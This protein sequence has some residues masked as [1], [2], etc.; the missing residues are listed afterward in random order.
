MKNFIVQS[1]KIY[2][3]GGIKMVELEKKDFVKGNYEGTTIKIKSLDIKPEST[4]HISYTIGANLDLDEARKIHELLVKEF[5][6]N[7]VIATVEEV[8]IGIE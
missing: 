5:P 6:N 8:E 3:G 4:I 2:N 1:V 7:N